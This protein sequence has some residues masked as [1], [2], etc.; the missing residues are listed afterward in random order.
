M[1]ITE[2]PQLVILSDL[3]LTGQSDRHRVVVQALQMAASH[4]PAAHLVVNGDLTDTGTAEQFQ[5]FNDIIAASSFAGR[6]WATLGNHD[7]RGP[8]WPD[9]DN[10]EQADPQHFHAVTESF[11]TQYLQSLP[12]IDRQALSFVVHLAAYQLIFLNTEKGLK[13]SAYF[14]PETLTWLTDQLAQAA[15]TGQ[16][17]LIFCHQ[18]LRQ[19]HWRS[20]FGGG[21]GLEDQALKQILT[22]YPNTYFISGHIHNGFGVTGVVERPFGTAIDLPALA[23]SENGHVGHSL[24]FITTLGAADQRWAASDFVDQTPLPQYDFQV[25]VPTT[26]A[27]MQTARQQIA[28]GHLA[29]LAEKLDQRF[30]QHL[31]DDPRT[32]GGTQAPPAPLYTAGEITAMQAGRAQ[33][34]TALQNGPLVTAPSHR[35]ALLVPPAPLADLAQLA[36]VARTL[37]ESPNFSVRSHLALQFAL[38]RLNVILAHPT[39]FTDAARTT[40]AKQVRQAIADLVAAPDKTG[41]MTGWRQ[42][43]ERPATPQSKELAAQVQLVLQDPEATTETIQQLQQELASILNH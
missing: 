26:A 4:A 29:A 37:W 33:L 9:W 35:P 36:F 39:E 13:D 19:T 6:T 16:P 27:L 30:D 25:A 40:A 5:E 17:T 10:S 24:G 7:V 12:E 34:L 31:F 18:P 15:A 22:A 38:A 14:S 2:S 42:L 23:V 3:H 41:L 1:A 11:Y 21:I 32:D 28:A 43:L 20:N 8:H